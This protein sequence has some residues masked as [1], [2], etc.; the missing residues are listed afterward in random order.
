DH[1]FLLDN[2]VMLSRTYSK[3]GDLR[4]A[5]RFLMEGNALTT[6]N[7]LRLEE[8]GIYKELSKLYKRKGETR[9]SL[10][11]QTKYI[12]LKDSVY[13]E[14]QTNN[15]MRLHAEG[16][17]KEH[18]TQLAAQERTMQ[19]KDESI[20]KQRIINILIGVV[21]IF[22]SILIYM[23]IGIFNDRKRTNALL[24]KKVKD[25]TAELERN[26]LDL[27]NAIAEQG[28]TLIQLKS[29]LSISVKSMH[30]LCST[31]I[32]GTP[33]ADSNKYFTE[34]DGITRNVS[35]SLENL[36]LEQ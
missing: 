13:N 25:R 7:Q 27:L 20:N 4:S 19:L 28:T 5:E 15:L 36:W 6:Q 35:R 10:F 26:R 11:Y 2:I 22:L 9:K 34:I 29:T 12:H 3:R 24:L 18:K 31:E 30:E 16:L 23:L 21:C 17:E 33:D 32:S 14:V 8:M 1:R